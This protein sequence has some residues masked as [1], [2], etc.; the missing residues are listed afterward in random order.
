MKKPN[1]FVKILA[2][3]VGGFLG[4][5]AM[6]SLHEAGRQKSRLNAYNSYALRE[7][8]SLNK[9]LPKML[10]SE[11]RLDKVAAGPGQFSYFFTLPNLAKSNLDLS[12]LQSRLQENATANYK[13]NNQLA[14]SRANNVVLNYQYKD[15]DGDFLF[16][17]EVSPKNF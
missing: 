14:S 3:L 8:E 6:E 10:D 15:Q 13:T 16:K 4:Y 9:E 17:F 1:Q 2:I 12:I 7:A 11:T 5:A